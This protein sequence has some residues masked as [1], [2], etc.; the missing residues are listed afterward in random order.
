MF[1]LAGKIAFWVWH[2][3]ST[4]MAGRQLHCPTSPSSS[5]LHSLFCPKGSGLFMVKMGE[6]RSD[7]GVLE[8]SPLLTT[9]NLLGLGWR[10]CSPWWLAGNWIAKASSCVRWQESSKVFESN[11]MKFMAENWGQ[12]QAQQCANRKRKHHS[13]PSQLGSAFA[14]SFPCAF[15][16]LEEVKRLHVSWGVTHAQARNLLGGF[17]L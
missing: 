5:P 3:A 14:P 15:L 7:F 11:I 4:V 6:R 13:G 10:R 1:L 2:L 17:S 12:A 9:D 16:V 8:V